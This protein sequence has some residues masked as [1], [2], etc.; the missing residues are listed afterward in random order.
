MRLLQLLDDGSLKLA[1][2]LGNS[3]PPYAILSHTWGS[4]NDEVTLQDIVNGTGQ[5]KAGYQKIL[6]CG[7]QAKKD[8][9]HYFWVD[10]CNIDKTSSQ[11][12]SEAINS[13][14]RWYQ[15]SERCY[16]YLS[17]V[18]A[19]VSNNDN[20]LSRGW[21]PAF[22]KSRWFTRG[23]TLQELIAPNSV[24]FF[25]VEE[26][27]LGDKRSLEQ[28]LHDI[29][30]IAAECLRGASLS[31]FPEEERMSWAAKRQTKREEDEAY[32]LLGI[33]D[34]SMPLIYGE[35]REKAFTRLE[36][37]IKKTSKNGFMSLNEEKKRILLDS[38]RFDQIDARQTAIKNATGKTCKWLL[39]DRSYLDWL[40]VDRLNDHHGFLWIKGKPGS[41]KSTLMKFAIV[42]GRKS[43][44]DKI[45]ISF[46]FHARGDV[47]EKSTIGAYQSLLLQLLEQLPAL[48]SVFE[49]SG[50]ITS[51]F[52]DYQWK[53][54]SLKWI[55]EQAILALGESSVVCFIDALDECDEEQIRDMVKFFE[56]V[57]KLARSASIR[58]QVCFASRH[59]PHITIERGI[60]LVLE[61]KEGHDQDITN[62]LESELKIGKSKIAQH[63]RSDIQEKALGVFM[64]VVLVVGILNKEHDR[65][66]IHALRRRLQEIPG[67]LHELFRDILTRDSR[68]KDELLLC[69]QWVLF[70]R[71]PLSPEQLYFAILSGVEPETGASPWNQDEIS[72]GD[73]ERFILD[74]SKGLVEVTA[75]KIRKVQFIHESVKDFLLR[76][77]GLS[78]IWPELKHNIQGQ[79]HERLKHCCLSH[80]KIEDF[81][82]LEIPDSVPKTPSEAVSLRGS[83]TDMF[84]FLEYSVQS[85]L[86]HAD[87]AEGSGIDQN[88][89]IHN[90][91]RL[92]WIRLDNIFERHQV[93]RHTER[94][95]ILYV[96]AEQNRSNLI[97]SYDYVTSCLD[98]E[99][100]RYGTPLFAAF[101]TGGEEAVDAFLQALAADHLE[102]SLPQELYSQYNQ[103]RV[104][105]QC[106]GRDFRFSKQK[107]VLSYAAE[108]GLA[109]VF[110]FLLKRGKLDS[111]MMQ[112]ALTPLF[113]A[114]R[115]GHAPI[116]KILLDSC[117]V[118]PDVKDQDWRT[119]LSWAAGNKN[120]AAVKMLLDTGKVDVDAKDKSGRTPLSW[121][122]G[123]GNEA[124]VKLLINTGKFDGDS[125]DRYGRTPLSWAAARNGSEAV[126]QD[127]LDTGKFDV[128]SEDCWK[129][130]PLSCAAKN[131]HKAVVKIILDTCKANV[132]VKDEDGRTPLS[133]AAWNDHEEVVQLLLNTGKVDVESKDVNGRTPLSWAACN[134][135][136]AVV[137]LLLDEGKVDVNAKDCWGQTPFSWAAQ[138]GHEAVVK[139]MLDTDQADVNA[140]D[141]NGRTPLWEAARNGHE[142]VIQTL[143][144]TGR[145]DI[146]VMIA[147]GST[148]LREAAR[149]GHEAVV[150]LLF[151]TG[152]ADVD[153]KDNDGRTPL[154][155]AARN[156]HEDVVQTLLDTGRVD[157]DVKDK[158]G[159]T[160]LSLAAGYGHESVVK[161][162][163]HTGKV[164]VDAKDRT[165]QTP[166]L[167]ALRS[168]QNAVA[169]LLDTHKS[170]SGLRASGNGREKVIELHD[171]DSGL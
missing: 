104:V 24:E 118:H 45:V 18:S 152:G 141:Q 124:I 145:V 120:E 22:R 133:L 109:P 100:E 162:L 111:R 50:V 79:S 108:L 68:N 89:F 7:N 127:L 23:W 32:C 70:S 171:L 52:V 10:T 98:V 167:W 169:K 55:M 71:L 113:L 29:T 131:G 44:K 143:L 76:E 85:I 67:D 96:L 139:L 107:G 83:F 25:S 40:D 159:K 135:S 153:V 117:K 94:M 78:H 149:N 26:E 3:H 72:R 161:L 91:P 19:G 6:F 41:G 146:D 116:V 134:G 21:K 102:K 47:M 20:E 38:L 114:A 51:N 16:V 101:A 60:S 165:G 77:D 31:L 9:L 35:R 158:Y 156:G 137:E 160:P 59:Y 123:F 125:K 86:Y 37:Q 99:N 1:E 33:F 110:S 46:F 90:F 130:T 147:A 48:Q 121:A 95:S 30:G 66:R 15:S 56:H 82:S 8:G 154:W 69:I 14:F 168:R 81:S 11:E 142:D 34:I 97:R 129:Q 144:D 39:K 93:R 170:G 87:M 155:E 132:D 36:E 62:Y 74:C 92:R 43:M 88:H 61:G 106:L 126:V 140:K 164:D 151:D 49:S 53:I 58:F 27:R 42:N 73:I 128:N 65:G 112:A 4:D 64:W 12:L 54:E 5:A 138:N 63:I 136:E 13:M 150:K 84:P 103:D 163:L 17:D 122:A 115:N 166:L 28:T 157:V 119:P 2:F 148:P 57:G 80:I 75:S 105:Q